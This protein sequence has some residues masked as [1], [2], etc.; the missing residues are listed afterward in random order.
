MDAREAGL[1]WEKN[2]EA[3]TVLSRQGYDIY[4]DGLNTPAFLAALPDIAGLTGLDVGCG[5]GH[6][7]RLLAA[8]GARL[9]GVD[10]SPAFIRFAAAA[11]PGTGRPIRYSI[12]SALALPFT[13]GAFDFATAFMSLMDLPDQAAAFD[14]IFRVLRPGGFL[15]FSI[16]HPCFTT[17]YRR[18]LRSPD[19]PAYA[20]EV[21]RYFDRPDGRIDR[22]TFSAA[23][24]D[25]RSSYPP[26][27]VPI[28]HRTLS[29]W[30]M[31][32]LR[33]GFTLEHIAEP[34][35]D[36]AAVRSFPALQD[37][38]ITAYF[39]HLRCRKP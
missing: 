36:E 3:W 16:T 22:W 4:R 1:H 6:N 35:A 2:A 29:E 30:I 37:T 5:E 13:S 23:P 12:G 34:S 27:E 38:Q 10:I 26:F 7:T 20:V 17:P 11:Q 15:Q 14:E 8:R 18:Q 21:G 39:L 19:G 32:I 31:T 24:P 28:F 33:A 9:V 25:L